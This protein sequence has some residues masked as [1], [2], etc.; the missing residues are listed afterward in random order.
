MGAAARL[1][2]VLAYLAVAHVASVTGDSRFAALALLA[3]AVLALFAPLLQGRIAAWLALAAAAAAAWQW[4]GSAALWWPLRL[5]PVAF[6]ALVA[7][8]FARTLREGRVPLVTRIA[9]ALRGTAPAALPPAEQGYARRVTLA[10]AVLL[11]ALALAD[12]WLAL[13]ATPEQWSWLANIG[14]YVVIAGFM[15]LEFAWRRHRFPAQREGF[16]AF[17]RRMAAL[18]PAFWRTVAS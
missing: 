2:L 14:D 17:L 1:L 9:A 16:A 15:A 6:V 10:W 3:V 4:S 18:G 8:A 5:V 13:H 7:A 12:L 11:G